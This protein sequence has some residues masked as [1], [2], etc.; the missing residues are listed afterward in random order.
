MVSEWS[1]FKQT[2]PLYEGKT[3]GREISLFLGKV[4]KTHGKLT[5][6]L[7]GVFSGGS[8]PGAVIVEGLAPI[9]VCS[10]CVVFAVTN[11]L[12]ALVLHALA[13][14]AIT[15]APGWGGGKVTD[16]SGAKAHR[17]MIGHTVL[18]VYT[19]CCWCA[20]QETKQAQTCRKAVQTQSSDDVCWAYHWN[21]TAPLLSDWVADVCVFILP[22]LWYSGQE[23]VVQYST[24]LRYA[25]L[26]FFF[27]PKSFNQQ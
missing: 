27:I 11:Q 12:A 6:T 8:S 7:V 26:F 16:R 4:D 2:I 19:S 14:M 15:L 23:Y 1:H 3:I 10:L 25:V 18:Y 21:V 13:G 24:V 5:Q 20:K 17:T 22:V 9:A